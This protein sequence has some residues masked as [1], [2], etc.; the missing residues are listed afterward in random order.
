MSDITTRGTDTHEKYGDSK[1]GKTRT[2]PREEAIEH[3]KDHNSGD[4]IDSEHEKHENCD[5]L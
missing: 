4:R 3:S 1:G 5:D 2:S